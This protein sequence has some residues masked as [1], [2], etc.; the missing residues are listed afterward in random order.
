MSTYLRFIGALYS[1]DYVRRLK[2]CRYCSSQF[3][4]VTN[5][6]LRNTCSDECDSASM[7]ITRKS[8]GNYV[9]TDEQKRK[10]SESCKTTH[11][12]REV[13]TVEH[14]KKFSETM[15]RTWAEGKINTANHWSKTPSGREHLSKSFTGKKMSLQARRRMS[16][17]AQNRLRTKRETLYSSARGGHRVDLGQYFRSAWEANFA[18]I[19]NYQGKTWSYEPTTFQLSDTMSYTPD[20][21][22]EGV[23][24]EIKGRMNDDA[25]KKLKFMSEKYPDVKIELIDSVKYNALRIQFKQLLTLTWEGK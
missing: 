16:I 2:T 1:C 21:L 3:S 12:S 13:F 10:K 25:I 24:Y 8:K 19:L 14:K 22:C 5:R 7:V 6:N 11:A 18:R 15:K 23:Y 17:S 4:D 9:Q 20:F